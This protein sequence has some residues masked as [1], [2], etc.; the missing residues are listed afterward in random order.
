MPSDID[1]DL[2]ELTQLGRYQIVQRLGGG[3]HAVVY[4][5]EDTL[6]KRPVALKVLKPVWASNTEMVSRFTREARAA[7]N[8]MHAHIAWVFDF[9]EIQ[10]FYYLAVR[11]VEGP[12]LQKFIAVR[13]KFHGRKHWNTSKSSAVH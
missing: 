9:G 4:K 7:G 12:T 3:A 13:A 8:L 11:Y 5:A 6:L 10:G 2:N 1:P